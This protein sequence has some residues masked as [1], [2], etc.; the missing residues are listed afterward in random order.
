M[1]SAI[2]SVDDTLINGMVTRM[3]TPATYLGF[4]TIALY[5][6]G[7]TSVDSTTIDQADW[8]AVANGATALTSPI[9]FT[10]N[11]SSGTPVTI[12]SIKLFNNLAGLLDTITVTEEVYSVVGTYTLADLT[13]SLAPATG[14]IV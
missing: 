7:G 11:G 3:I 2:V 8:D 13:F 9:L 5:E 6:T 10:V 14:I 12:S 1:A 4:Y